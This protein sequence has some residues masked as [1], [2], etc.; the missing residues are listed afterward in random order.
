M[1]FGPPEGLYETTAHALPFSF[2]ARFPMMAGLFLYENGVNDG[3]TLDSEKPNA[4]G[5]AR[6]ELVQDFANQAAVAIEN[7]RWCEEAT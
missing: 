4:F 3:L 1:P 2:Q 5:T 6:V 7:T